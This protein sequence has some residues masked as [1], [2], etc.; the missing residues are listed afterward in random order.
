MA[1]FKLGR[2]KFVYQ[3]T[4]TTG[5]GYVVDDV[6]TVGG[7]TYICTTSNTASATFATDFS[8]G[9]WSV[10]ADGSRWTGNWTNNQYY[11]VNDQVLYG[12]VVYLC[13]T[14]HTSAS[15]TATITPTAATANGTTATLTFTAL[16]S[17]IQPFLVG[18]S[19][20]VS[21]FS[22]QTGFNGTFTVTA[23]TATTVSYALA[24]SLTG[25]VMGTVSGTGTLGLEVNQ[26][27]WTS[28]AS[29]FNWT[30][31]WTI[32]TRYKYNDLVSYG[33]L[34]YICNTAHVSANTTTLGLEANQS[35]WTVFNTGVAY[36]GLW[37]GNST[38]Y[39]I[40]DIV[41]YGASLWICTTAHTSSGTFAS[42]NFS[43]FVNGLE[44]VSGG[45]N[46]WVGSITLTAA[47]AS[48]GTA[49][50][51]F[52]TQSA[53]PFAVGQSI[54]VSGVTPSSFNGTF[55]VTGTPTTTQ[56]SYALAGSL[57]GS[58]FGTVAANY[59]TGDI[60]SYGGNLY[61]AIASNTATTPSTG[62][63][64][65]QVFSTG[66]SFQGDWS[67]LTSYK[68][69][70]VVRLGGYTYMA[71]A[72]NA[73][74]T[75]IANQTSSGSNS[76]SV[77]ATGSL[78]ANLPIV[79]S[80]TS[81]G[82]IV[83]GTTY[84]VGTIIDSTHITLLTSSGGSTLAVTNATGSLT[85]TT[86]SQP[87]FSTYWT[88]L[89]AGIRW[90]A[91]TTQSYNGLSGTN[92]TAAGSGAQFNVTTSGTT[93]SVTVKSG[94]QGT[95]Y[96][97]STTLKILGTQVGGISPA[98]D[99]TITITG[100]TAGAI[101]LSSGITW[102]GYSV[103]W[104]TASNYVLGDVVYFG[105]N[106][107]IC[108]SAHTSASGNRPDA[109]T[110]GTYWNLLASGAESAVLTTQGD[111]AYYGTNGPT[112]LPVGTDGQILRV[113]GTIPSWAYYGQI[114]NIV[115]VSSTTGVDSLGASQGTTIDKPWATI[116]YACY[117]IENGYLNT[118]TTGL[119]SINKQFMLKEIN[120]YVYYSY[121]FNVTGTSVQTITVGGTSSIA[122]TVTTNMYS[123]M[124]IVFTQT[125]GNI[126]AGTTYFVAQV[127]NSTSFN[128]ATTY[129]NATAA[130]PT[131]FT[132]GTGSA[133][134]GTYSYNQAKTER[135]TGTVIDGLLFD[136]GRGGNYKTTTNA[137]AYFANSTTFATN[138]NAYDIPPFVSAL[139]YL[140]T[141]A[142]NYVLTNTSAAVSYQST[143]WPGVTIT[144]ASG[145][146]AVATITFATQPYVYPVGQFITVAG[147]NPSGYN[148]TYIVV[149]STLTSVSYASTTTTSY[150]SGGTVN[151]AR[152]TQQIN[153]GYTAELT[154]VARVANLISII[155]SPLTLGY[156]TNVQPAATPNTTIFVKTG[157]YNEVLPIVVPSYTSIIGDE[158]RGTVV[159]PAGPNLNMI[160]DKTRSINSLTRIQSLI[161]NLLQ[162][163]AITPTSGNTQYLTVTGASGTGSVATLTFASQTSAPFNVNQYITVTSVNPSGYNGSYIVTAVTT[164]SVSY[165]STTSASYVSGGVVSGQATGL[166]AGDVGSTTVVNQINTS[167][168][169]IN[170]MIYNGLPKTP[171]ITIPQ[172][173]G[174]N[175][176]YLVGFGYG[177]T[178]IQNNYLFIKAEIAA[179][180]NTYYS[181]VW[182]TFG[183]T[184]QT[185]TL[186]DIGFVLDG[187]QYDMTYGCNNQSIINGS[188]YYSLQIPQILASYN[189]ATVG[190]LQRL[191]A[192]ISQI[193][194]GTSV[195]ATSGNSVTQSTGG[196]AGSA[197]AASFAAGRVG[198]VIYWLQNATSNATTLTLVGSVSGT[199]LTVTSGTGNGIY[200]GSMLTGTGVV[201][202]TYIVNQLT[203]SASATAATTLA[204]GGSAGTNTFVVSSATGIAAGQLITGT[205]LPAGSYVS[206]SYI[207]GT[208]ITVV[209]AFG[210]P[211]NFTSTGGTGAYLFYPAN[212]AGTYT[213][214]TSGNTGTTFTAL[215]TFTPVTSGAYALVT[216]Q[217]LQ[218]AYNNLIARQTEIASDAQVWVQKYYQA[219][220]ISQSLTQRDAGYIAL[221]LAWDVLFGTN[222]NSIACGRAF[223]RLNASALALVANTNQELNATTGA[224][225][226]IGFKAKQIASA[227]S[228]V[229]AQTLIDDIVT[230]IN[231]QVAFNTV[232]SAILAGTQTIAY[233][234]ADVITVTTS[235][236]T[237][238]FSVSLTPATTGQTITYITAGGLAT[239]SSAQTLV[240]GTSV[241]LAA[242]AGGMSAGTYYVTTGVNNSFTVSLSSSYANAV[243][244]TP[245]SFTGGT[246]T[247][248]VGVVTIGT[249]Y[250]TIASVTVTSGG[251]W[252]NTSLYSAAQATTT[253]S[254]GQGLTLSLGFV[255]SSYSTTVAGVQTSSNIVTLG[256]TAGMSTN[257]P[258]TFSGLPALGSVTATATTTTSNL[259]TVATTTG[260]SVGQQVYFTGT[261]FGNIV[262]S[263]LY[264]IASIPTPGTNGTITVSLTFGGGNVA[265]ISATGTMTMAFN[266]AGGLWNNTTYWIN[267]LQSAATLSTLAITSTTGVF[268]CAT[269]SVTLTVGQPVV[270]TGTFS[271]GSITGYTSGATYYIIGNPT[272]TAFQLSATL[273]GSA[274][275]STT[276]GG[277]ITGITVTVPAAT[278]T[279][280]NSFKSGTAYTITNTVTGMS[281][282]TTA[283]ATVTWPYLNNPMINGSLTYND[284]VLTI[285]GTEIL[286]ANIPFLAAEAA[287][288]T[289]ASYGGTVSSITS[290]SVVNTSGAHN[291]LVNDPV[292][293][294]GTVGSSNIVAG[295]TYYVLTVPSSTTFTISA[296][297]YGTGTQTIFTLATGSLGSLTVGYYYNYAKCVRDTTNFI[298]ALIYDINY[299][300]NWKSM[301]AAE[302]YVNAVAGST[303]QNF[304]LV[305]NA[306]GIRNQ[307][308]N[309]LTGVLSTANA[310]GTRRPT[311]GAYA[312]LDPGFGPNDQNA[313]VY[314]RSTFVQ[315][316]T[317]FG[318]AC[319]GAKVDG[320]LHAGGYKS[321]VANDYTCV[322]GDGIGW[323]T[324]GTGSL[325]ELVSVF[326]Y[327]SYAGYM[328]ELGGRIRAT[329]GNS[330]YGTY[331]VVAEGVDTFETPIY[332]TVNNR[333]YGPQVTNVVTDSTT[334]ILRLEYENAGTNYTNAVPTISGSGYNILSFADEFRDAGV[335][336]SRLIDLNNG[337]GVGGSSYVSS[338]NVG[339][340]GAV[341]YITIA[342]ADVALT[343]S[344]NGMKVQITAGTGVGQYASILTYT[345]GSKIAQIIRTTFATL[346]VTG[347][348]TTA[349]TVASTATLYVGMPIYLS[350][351]ATNMNLTAYQV[352]YV[353]AIS[354]T[355]Q[356]TL[357][358]TSGGSAITGLTATSG[359]TVSLYAAGWDHVVPGT[360]IVNTLD[361]TT[362]YIIEPY[363]SFTG[364]GY[365]ATART[366]PAT[367]IWSSIT[368][369]AGNYVA[370]ANGSTSTA[371]STNG[372]TWTS[373]G[374]LTAS[375]FTNVVYGGGQGAAATVTLGG[376]GGSG[377]QL[378]AV[379]GTGTSLGQV[380]GV[381]VINGGYNYNTAPSLLFTGGGGTGAQGTAVVL[382]GVIQSVI[383]T[384]NGSGYTSAPTVT[385]V[386]SAITAIT[387]ITWGKNYFNSGN[388]SVTISA[389]FSGTVWSGSSSAT[390]G[391]YYYYYSGATQATNYYLA[392]SSGTFSSTAPTF[393][394]G[395]GSAGTYG[396]SLTFVG[397]AATATPTLTDYGVSSYTI[398]NIGYGYTATPTITILDTSA[399]FVAIST[400]TTATA[401][402]TVANLGSSWTSG[403]AL[404]SAGFNSL[405]YGN[406]IYVAVGYTG[407][408]SNASAIIT[409]SPDGVT[410]TGRTAPSGATQAFTSVAFGWTGPGSSATTTGMFVAIATNST[411]TAYSTNGLTWTTG[412]A[413][414]SVANWSSVTYGNGRF[415]AVAA[416]SNIVAYS[417]N[418]GVTWY[419]SV[420]NN[421]TYLPLAQNWGISYGEGQ[422][423]ATATGPTP[424]MTATTSSGNLI[425]LSSTAG[426]NVGNTI[427]P[428]AVTETTVASQTINATAIGLSTSFISNGIAGN[429]GTTLTAP[430]GLG[431]FALG[432]YLTGSN[433]TSGTYITGSNTFNSTSS[434]IA[435]SILTIGGTVTGTGTTSAYSVQPGMALTGAQFN[436][437]SSYIWNTYYPSGVQTGVFVPAGTTT[438][439]ITTGSQ[440]SGTN[441]TTGATYI[442]SNPTTSGSTITGTASPSTVVTF[443][444]SV[445]IVNGQGILTVSSTPSG[446]GIQP[447]YILSGTGVTA[448]TTIVA[449][450]GSST[451]PTSSTGQW[452]VSVATVVS[453]TALTGTPYVLTTTGTINN[454][455]LIPGMVLAS[456]GGTGTITAGTYITGQ[457]STTSSAVGTGTG[458]S[459]TI[460]T[461]TLVISGSSTGFAVGQ[462]ITGGSLFFNTYVVAVSVATN[463]TITLSQPLYATIGGGTYNGY[464]PGTAGQYYISTTSL[465]TS[466]TVTGN[467]WVANTGSL[468]PS[469]TITGGLTAYIAYQNT[470]SASAVASPSWASGGT[471]GASSFVVNTGTGIVA[472][473]L[474]IGTGIPSGTVVA[475]S[476]VPGSTTVP[477]A[478]GVAGGAA[479][480][481]AGSNATGTYNF[482]TAGGTGTY[483]L[484][485]SALTVSSA[486]TIG[487]Q[488]WT[489]TPSQ[490]AAAGAITGTQNTITV[491]NTAGMSVGEPIVFTSN[492]VSTTLT[493]TAATGNLLT[494]GT[495]VG[496][497]VG[498]PVVFTAVTQTGNITSTSSTGN[499]ITLNST[500]GLVQGETIVFTAVSQ[501][502]TLTATTN[503]SFTLSSS[504]ITNSILTVGTLS[505]GTI[506]PGAVISGG[507]IP[508]GTYIISNISGSG[509]G[510]TWNV[511]T[512]SGFTQTST[513]ITGTLNII[514]VNSNSGMLI[515]ETFTVATNVG[516]LISGNTYYITKTIS[517]NQLAVGTVYGATSDLT[518]VTTTG[519]SVS[520]TAGATLGGGNLTA[521][522]TFYITSVAGSNITI[523]T[524]YNGS[525]VTIANGTGVWTFVA[526]A[527][528]GSITSGTTYYVTSIPTPGVNGTITVSTTYG[529]SNLTVTNGN[530][531][532][533]VTEGATFGGLTS[534]STYFI[535]EIVGSTLISVS[536]I[537]GG[538]NAVVTNA[539][540]SWTAQA[541]SLFGNLISGN[542]YYIAS[543]AGNQITVSASST[544]SPVITLVNDTGAWTSTIGTNIAATSWDGINWTQQ[545]LPTYA[546]WITPSFGNPLVTT[547]GYTPL[548]V[549][550]SNQSG[551]V[552]ASIHTGA[553]PLARTKVASGALTEIRMI[554]PGSGFAKGVVTGTTYVAGTTVTVTAASG[555]S[556]TIGATN[557]TIGQPITFATGFGNVVANTTYYVQVTS[558][559]TTLTISSTYYGS[560][561]NAGTASS[562]SVAGTVGPLNL[563]TVDQTENMYN[564]QP[565]E[566]N[567][568][569]SGGLSTQTT[570]Y[571][572]GSTIQSTTFQVATSSALATIGTSVILTTSTPTGMQYTT[573]PILTITDPNQ[574]NKAP[575]RVRTGDGVLGNPSFPCRGAGNATATAS[576][577]GDGYADIY[578][579][580]AFIN[581]ANL[582]ALPAAGANVQFS[583]I[584]NAWYKLVATSNQLGQ[585][586]NYTATFQVSPSL[587][588]YL[589]P[590]NGALI[591]TRLKYSQ[592]RLTGHDFLYVGSGNQTQT[593]YPNVTDAN[594]I[595]ANQTY[596]N[597]GGRVFFTSTD[598]DGNFNV[599]NLFGV[600]Q[601]TGTA[602]LNAN[603][604]NLAGLQSL[605]LGSVSLGVNSATITQFST[606]PYFTANSDNILPTQ[607]AIKSYITAQIGGGSSSLNVN[608]LTAGQ[609]YI[610]G[611]TISNLNGN[612]I[613]VSSKMLFTG[614]IDGA[615][616]ATVFFLS[617]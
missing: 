238:T 387:P 528:F 399:K 360:P 411:S 593:N 475:S 286:R 75:I 148:G 317:M 167:V 301:R 95:G 616:V 517:T 72:D 469:T 425:T 472:G 127:I 508:A 130:S 44:Y 429:A 303:T 182:T 304:Y 8:S 222:F 59:V 67:G 65:W 83:S 110:T 430:V 320:A 300:G 152:A 3:G 107:Y 126:V 179:Y 133:N 122:Q 319:V 153:T 298:N 409:S 245:G 344:Y 594:A 442:V 577:T 540:G 53:I 510:S 543:I 285:Q 194:T 438:G 31:A 448:G 212:G 306:C 233:G 103:T 85:G 342:A 379:I 336:E 494:V 382:N 341:G 576:I 598:Q 224:I 308:M 9:Y 513:S 71:M 244:G 326:N 89:N 568:V 47:S 144:G 398:T 435:G 450:Y 221:A 413:L 76:V 607:K 458:V 470:S 102:T 339:Q 268:S 250:N 310:Y 39:R 116:R 290:G 174:Y 378:T 461:T 121:S 101:N 91:G 158:L 78:V 115:Y 29:S 408:T 239:F 46:A 535:T 135:D 197:A 232:G 468:V 500:T 367:T 120:N 168:S 426:L 37:N 141:L 402:S 240:K 333:S 150:V 269:S 361:L 417:N 374:A 33:G 118:N 504:S 579:N 260:L 266:N 262:P 264:Y 134:I 199:T 68:I 583:S 225:T 358:L 159:Q 165:T 253:T 184:N 532:W 226:F 581:V 488:S 391:S 201:A 54:T 533:S 26:S 567:T 109:D 571:V 541:G 412:G 21:G 172:L 273:G 117:Q 507:S 43:V 324:T 338:V 241:T 213:L 214:S 501:T 230:K 112:R 296:T 502:T 611:N 203:S 236:G 157:T 476:Y 193:V 25:T 345:N 420:A 314:A 274:V 169:L 187:L 519:Q 564:L 190:A 383:I 12:G 375:A 490:T 235:G 64:S 393:T 231:G 545:T 218:T 479:A 331:G 366:L 119:L 291:L 18:A 140:N 359:Q 590:P 386:T 100:V 471:I 546:S 615:P 351:T 498:A 424:T 520:V 278:L 602:T 354:S 599:G 124:P 77:S 551:T 363:V 542:T 283:G 206:S 400:T 531:S 93:Y 175:T 511:S 180:L 606:D 277:T 449:P 453:S 82:N 416:G 574:V 17:N 394:T 396:V 217:Y 377:A 596:P 445:S 431:P 19:I 514:T 434:T 114:N 589:A 177:I 208:S 23:C 496:M 80:G 49:T 265:L 154:G 11:L 565:I 131:L 561:F 397:T 315:N 418:G 270:I 252:N 62:T 247:G 282:T 340:G 299:T 499:T 132:V 136:I 487:G 385:V 170:D 198:D 526:G 332:G 27:N 346:T 195:T 45:N 13:T 312:S 275:T 191:Q 456:T 205:N 196:S 279:L 486:Q 559:G 452:I 503:G 604:F 459:G 492:I 591:T 302:L 96:S 160:N 404:P 73:Q 549:T 163:T 447:G 237:A 297:Q 483:T 527:A 578:Q 48:G 328:S 433:V 1:Q 113:G 348:S 451:T 497:A 539:G 145:T 104:I 329:N 330:S 368:Y 211:Q 588:T 373:G 156:T 575:T 318:Y 293:F 105:A 164:N 524:V 227:G 478:V 405:T 601:A 219:Y 467:A 28:F 603:A 5:T 585:A 538:T 15:S 305:R 256:S 423:F 259:I 295:T 90:N 537:Y 485:T 349:L 592:T 353:Q 137:L 372:K 79:F 216:N 464:I 489:I 547:T 32:N 334:Q 189:A 52:A 313:W 108:V 595:Q 176:S 357:A 36:Q 207:S 263:Q 573:G 443:N 321:M 505:A 446:V 384:V 87:P 481:I 255:S 272:S 376:F 178:Q 248:A 427:V 94:S 473:Q 553:T 515:G 58:V 560:P 525:S 530:G 605:T 204:S 364:P 335:F 566:F 229:Q 261:V 57:T 597:I 16:S 30:G 81:F 388:V 162:N 610:A 407:T 365:A 271:A 142:T 147:V 10:V 477:L 7:R 188:S 138:V 369:G 22:A 98:N 234:T 612:Q 307:T 143:V 267:S 529:G 42:A 580:T 284:N 111:L 55:I 617:R 395:T 440:L 572:I 586:G 246:V 389:P 209:N 406:G 548:W 181:S 457:I 60:V 251:N 161:P 185:E 123:G 223:N 166:P 186:R 106:S 614:G 34:N 371:I 512:S 403:N 491:G 523:S 552:A 428:T 249:Y 609:I 183:G 522:T 61:T 587:T 294:T 439:V 280:T 484:N 422:F 128:I 555:N 325:S 410:W 569:S 570:Y 600:Q 534:G 563:I 455:T 243:A 289:V 436:T 421:G 380:V 56:V 444:G 401:Y 495:T 480:T 415:V 276:S 414:P 557:L 582:Y 149:A 210:A 125:S 257:M 97:A 6:V 323:W 40:N 608:T 352:Y 173:T 460:G 556:I 215:S 441:I 258:I 550:A 432:M 419:S 558:S 613:Y 88:R 370:I 362:A 254:S 463:T 228:T 327:Y 281:A 454:N 200:I 390:S 35:S 155:T 355:T 584:S 129:A 509:N 146:G 316:C 63:A 311:A 38:H 518:L 92:I 506:T 84:Y 381:N 437:T 20:T 4:W 292:V 392:T 171:A 151:V 14:A 347:S 288:Y 99:I 562:I 516:N 356:F 69:G 474:I 350:T 50:L 462:L 41:K 287:A 51:S 482:Y 86:Q 74:Q 220:P 521:S 309:G 66:F 465:V 139:N 202:G 192:I 337:L 343:G 554:E 544:L 322:I 2:I 493:T 536:T 242:A 70:Q 466:V 24:Q